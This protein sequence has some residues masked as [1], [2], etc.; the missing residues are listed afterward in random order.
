MVK[1]TVQ[2]NKFVT[3]CKSHPV[4]VTKPKPMVTKF[5]RTIFCL[6][7]WEEF[8]FICISL[9]INQT[10]LPLIHTQFLIG[11]T[12]TLRTF[13][14]WIVVTGPCNIALLAEVRGCEQWQ[15]TLEAV[16]S[17]KAIEIVYFVHRQPVGN[18]VI[19]FRGNYIWIEAL[20]QNQGIKFATFGWI[21]NL[22]PS[23]TLG[24]IVDYKTWKPSISH[25][26]WEWTT[27]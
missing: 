19:R 6:A 17:G 11:I 1:S 8:I 23:S 10:A 9:C 7:V 20:P 25:K 14:I 22:D 21:R 13:C 15:W 16:L 27:I 12:L 26:F 5:R 4:S 24:I 3:W 18:C 2:L